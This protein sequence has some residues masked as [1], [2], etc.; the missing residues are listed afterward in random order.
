MERRRGGTALSARAMLALL[1]LTGAIWN[2]HAEGEGASQGGIK[3]L[4]AKAFQV[5]RTSS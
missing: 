2:S 4:D 1:C 3:D 5:C